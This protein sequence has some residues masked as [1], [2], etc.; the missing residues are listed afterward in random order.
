M[1]S[2]NDVAEQICTLVAANRHGSQ[3][4]VTF[5]SITQS[6]AHSWLFQSPKLAPR[7]HDKLAAGPHNQYCRAHRQEPVDDK[8]AIAASKG[9][10]V[11]VAAIGLSADTRRVIDDRSKRGRWSNHTTKLGPRL[12]RHSAWFPGLQ[13]CQKAWDPNSTGAGSCIPQTYHDLDFW[14][15]QSLSELV[16]CPAKKRIQGP[17]CG[18]NERTSEDAIRDT[19]R[20]TLRLKPRGEGSPGKCLNVQLLG[21]GE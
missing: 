1:R 11:G 16:A 3:M 8:R 5:P 9:L 7:T 18:R 13:R 21:T 20:T 6:A 12:L 10:S 19:Y 15:K 2:L 4:L 17:V 14:G